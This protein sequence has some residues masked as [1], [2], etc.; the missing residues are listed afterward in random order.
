MAIAG[1]DLYEDRLNPLQQA[2]VL[3]HL[4][5]LSWKPVSPNKKETSR[6][7]QHYGFSYS[8][9]PNAKAAP[10]TPFPPILHS[11]MT[12]I[13]PSK[14]GSAQALNQVIVNEYLTRAGGGSHCKLQQGITWHT[15]NVHLFGDRVVCFTFG[16]PAPMDF[17][18]GGLVRTLTPPAGSVYSMEG[19]A[20]WRAQHRMRPAPALPGRVRRRVS[21][22]F[23]HVLPAAARSQL[24]PRPLPAARNQPTAGDPRPPSS[25]CR[26]APAPE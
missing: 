14:L 7:V 5:Q 23:R 10:T 1:L 2:Q 25:A 13:P 4:D 22:T 15:D 20:R 9:G 19:E 3:Y 8:Y 26:T 6:R 16:D 17:R 12:F 21:V 11:L 18:V 24:V